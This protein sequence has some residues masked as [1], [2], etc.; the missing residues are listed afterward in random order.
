[1]DSSLTGDKVEN[2]EEHGMNG[3][4]LRTIHMP[5]MR[6]LVAICQTLCTP[7]PVEGIVHEIH[8]MG[9]RLVVGA[10]ATHEIMGIEMVTSAHRE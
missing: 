6:R 2:G 10:P 8:G 4:T 1:M 7:L 3:Q 5:A 9:G